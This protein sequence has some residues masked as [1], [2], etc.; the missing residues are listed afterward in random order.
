M[1]DRACPDFIKCPEVNK[2]QPS[3]P[4]I[5]VNFSYFSSLALITSPYLSLANRRFQ[6]LPIYSI[7]AFSLSLASLYIWDS[8]TN[9][10]PSQNPKVKESL[11]S[12]GF[13]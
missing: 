9:R 6:K 11:G 12:R 3:A 5:L 7:G 2:K 13:E 10:K 1:I 8:W 4:P